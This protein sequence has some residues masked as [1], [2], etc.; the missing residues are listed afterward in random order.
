MSDKKQLLIQKGF[1]YADGQINKH[2][3]NLVSGTIAQPFCETLWSEIGGDMETINRITEIFVMMNNDKDR[4][5][6][7]KIIQMLFGVTGVL[8]PDEAAYM[9][10]DDNVLKYFIFSFTADFGELIQE[11]KN[12]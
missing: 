4:N 5:K 9:N 11:Y 1:L 8:F 2:K 6:L 7:Y 10:F 12:E 3:I